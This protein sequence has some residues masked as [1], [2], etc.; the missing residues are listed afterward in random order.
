MNPKKQ[1]FLFENPFLTNDEGRVLCPQL[2]MQELAR[3]EQIDLIRLSPICIL[4]LIQENNPSEQLDSDRVLGLSI[5]MFVSDFNDYVKF[6][7]RKNSIGNYILGFMASFQANFGELSRQIGDVET[8]AFNKSIPTYCLNGVV[9]NSFI[10]SIPTYCQ[11]GRN[12]ASNRNFGIFDEG[13][14]LNLKGVKGFVLTAPDINRLANLSMST[15]LGEENAVLGEISE[16]ILIQI[17]YSIIPLLQQY[18]ID[19]ISINKIVEHIKNFS[20]M[21]TN[22]YVTLALAFIGSIRNSNTQQKISSQSPEKQ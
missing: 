3:N 8:N 12:Q 9:T 16:E 22:I 15:R 11:L 10:E 7:S 4:V 17:T 5:R 19:G 2:S 6:D 20:G 1:A 18:Q 21:Y 13:S 14:F